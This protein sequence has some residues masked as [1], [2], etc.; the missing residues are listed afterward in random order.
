M[1]PEVL[2]SD[3]QGADTWKRPQE[4]LCDRRGERRNHRRG[5][6][7]GPGRNHRRGTTMSEVYIAHQSI[8]LSLS[9]SLYLSILKSFLL[10]RGSAAVTSEKSDVEEKKFYLRNNINNWHGWFIINESENYVCE[11]FVLQ[12]FI[13]QWQNKLR[14][15]ATES[16][17][18]DEEEPLFFSRADPSFI[19]SCTRQQR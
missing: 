4:Q 7:G 9:L 11:L 12:S 3:D 8:S 13:F 15:H 10:P 17:H 5:T 2:R 16:K 1:R 18:G 14:K 6:T 19:H